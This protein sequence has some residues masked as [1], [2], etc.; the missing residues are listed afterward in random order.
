MFVPLLVFMESW[1]QILHIFLVSGIV[2]AVGFVFYLCKWIG[3][4]DAKFLFATTLWAANIDIMSFL[5]VVVLAGGALAIFY[6]FMAVYID[7]FRGLLIN[8]FSRLFKN[9]TFCQSYID[10][11][12]VYANSASYRTIKIPYGMA[13]TMGSLFINILLIMG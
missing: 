4:G 12:F 6:I 8:Y 13:I 9:S 5:I 7:H 1:S 3:A 2:L 11:P 10:K